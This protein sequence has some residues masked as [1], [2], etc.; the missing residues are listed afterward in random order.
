[1]LN[2]IF[3]LFL[4]L[5]FLSNAQT[6]SPFKWEFQIGTVATPLRASNPDRD[7]TQ[8]RNNVSEVRISNRQWQPGFNAG[9]QLYKDDT[10][11]SVAFSMFLS[12][13]RQTFSYY[14]RSFENGNTVE[15][16]NENAR[17]RTAWINITLRA[18][19]ALGQSERINVSGGVCASHFILNNNEDVFTEVI[20][21]SAID[22]QTGQVITTSTTGTRNLNLPLSRIN[23]GLCAGVEAQVSKSERLPL[24]VGLLYLHGFTNISRDYYIIHSGLNLSLLFDF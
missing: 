8:Q 10:R 24:K 6:N 22:P 11:F 21:Q 4:L 23:F 20:S 3:L 12:Y 14:L 19:Y 18:R 5:P 17:W 16:F 15:L 7:P 2:R 1:M 13:H 9:M